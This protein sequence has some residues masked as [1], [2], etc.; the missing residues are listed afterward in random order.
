V[1]RLEEIRARVLRSPDGE[2]ARRRA[3]GAGVSDG[4]IFGGVLALVVLAP[5]LYGSDH[6]GALLLL[7]SGAALLL[8]VWMLEI[9]VTGVGRGVWSWGHAGMLGVLGLALLQLAPLPVSVEHVVLPE[10]ETLFWNRLTRDPAAT[11]AAAATWTLLLVYFFLLALSVRSPVRIR[12][13]GVALIVNGALLSLLGLVNASSSKDP[14]FWSFPPESPSFGP[15]AN[16]AHFSVLVEMIVP[17]ALARLLAVG[18]GR[19]GE[20]P[21]LMVALV[22]MGAAI[23]RAASRAGI[24]LVALQCVIVPMAIWW[25][26][27]RV[28][29][30]PALLRAGVIMGLAIGGGAWIGGEGVRER[31]AERFREDVFAVRGEIWRGTLRMIADHPVFGVGL[32]AFATMYP[33]YDEGNGLRYTAEAHNEYLQLLA[34]TGIVGG[35]IGA[36]F[37]ISL[38]RTV[39]RSFSRTGGADD[40]SWAVGASTGIVAAL[41]HSGVDFGLRIPANALVFLSLLTVLL[42]LDRER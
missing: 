12:V 5:W 25:G 42:R 41:L 31:I 32:G 8:C 27:Q 14:I 20:S 35:I 22:L 34:E 3:W 6:V 40:A 19:R 18:I 2:G 23:G 1:R 13:L 29:F 17:L 15:Y 28:R 11:A 39:W 21:W 10:G 26:T 38:L 4:V 37:L 7:G 33:R 30:R 36:A 9:A 24:V 16:R